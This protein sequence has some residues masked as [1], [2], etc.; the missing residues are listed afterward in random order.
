MID[1]RL[2]KRWKITRTL[3]SE[4]AKQLS[5]ADGFALYE[6]YIEHNELELALSTLEDLAKH[7]PVDSAFWRNLKRAADVMGLR[8]RSMAF[9]Q[10]ARARRN[11]S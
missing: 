11:A 6:E 4:A 5:A 1:E 7:T 8:E 2:L 10:Q 3:L 9:R